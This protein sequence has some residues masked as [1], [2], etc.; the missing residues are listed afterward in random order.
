MSIIE[1]VSVPEGAAGDWR[2][3]RFEITKHEAM[4]G[5]IR[6]MQHGRGSVS[7]GIYTKLVHARRGL[8]MSDTPDEMRDHYPIIIAATGHV[9]LNG[10]GI[11]M[12]LAAVLK[13]NGV[14]RLSVVE[15]EPDVIALA[16]PHYRKDP[17]VEIIC[18]DAFDYKPPKGTHYG[19]V[20]HDIWDNLCVD[21]LEQMTKLKR[22]YGRHADWQGCWGEYYIRRHCR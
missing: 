13:R 6:A 5:S 7:P 20:W 22:R 8:V 12:V 9:L 2:I 15:K 17:R 3:E 16:G 11:G 14:S 19:A 18:A 21:N 4:I 10:L 1:Q